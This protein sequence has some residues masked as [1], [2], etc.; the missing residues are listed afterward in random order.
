MSPTE[1]PGQIKR[2][3]TTE[4]RRAGWLS[5]AALST[6]ALT[7]FG[8]AL[9]DGSHPRAAWIATLAVCAEVI[10]ALVATAWLSRQVVAHAGAL[11]E[12][13][14]EVEQARADADAEAKHKARLIALLDAALGCSPVGF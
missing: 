10:V 3:V 1:R 4:L 6:I 9:F 12:S 5:A 14:A 8:F 2:G 7:A 11:E 13:V